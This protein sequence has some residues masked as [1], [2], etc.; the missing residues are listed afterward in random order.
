MIWEA[1]TFEKVSLNLKSDKEKIRTESLINK[2][3]IQCFFEVMPAY[4]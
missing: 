4:L 1:I 2:K 3:K